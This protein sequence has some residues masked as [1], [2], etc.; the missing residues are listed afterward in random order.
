[1][2]AL[3]IIS[4]LIVFISVPGCMVAVALNDKAYP[5][6]AATAFMVLGA[7]GFV[8]FVLGRLFD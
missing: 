1:M 7:L 6:S 5:N 2:K 3:K 8:G 4:A